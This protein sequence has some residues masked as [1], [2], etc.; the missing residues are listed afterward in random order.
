MG[1]PFAIIG[2]SM[3][4]TLFFIGFI[5][6]TAALVSA[7]LCV[8]FLVLFLSVKKLRRNKALLLSV[9][10]SLLAAGLFILSYNVYYLPVMKYV[11]K[12]MSFSGTLSDYP[13]YKYDRY[14]YEIKVNAVNGEKIAPFS[15]R[16]SFD[17]PVAADV[18]DTMVFKATAFE[19]SSNNEIGRLN[20]FSKKIFLGASSSGQ[21]SVIKNTKAFKGFSYY[22]KVYRHSLIESLQALM[23]DD[24][25]A[26]SS[27]VLTGDKSYIDSDILEK[28]NSVS[29]SHIICVSGLHLSIIGSFALMLFRK[30]K[31]S[32]KLRYFAAA[33]LI[34]FFMALCGFTSSILRAGI[35]FLIYIFAELIL[36]EPDSEN[37]LGFAA[38]IILLINPFTAVNIG[39]IF[40]FSATLSIIKIGAPLCEKY[41]EKFKITEK[42]KA[43]KLLFSLA[44]ILIIS[45][46]VNFIC[47][48]FSALIFGK[49]S[50][51]GIVANVL[52]LPF[53]SLLL[54]SSGIAALLGLLPIKIFGIVTYPAAF[55]N[56]SISAYTLK[57][58]ELLSKTK[59][60]SI[61]AGDKII[62]F[63]IALIIILIAFATL[64][65]KN[66]KA[67]SIVLICSF[68]LL[69]I[70]FFVSLEASGSKTEITAL[71]VG[72]GMCISIKCEDEFYLIDT[73]SDSNAYSKIKESLFS[74]MSDGID[75]LV[76]TSQS[77]SESGNFARIERNIKT[78]NILCSNFNALLEFSNTSNTAILN[79]SYKSENGAVIS[80]DEENQAVLFEYKSNRVLILNSEKTPLISLPE[81][82]RAFNYL[83]V[84][85]KANKYIVNPALNGI[86]EI[87]KTENKN[88]L[89]GYNIYSTSKGKDV[90]IIFSKYDN[91]IGYLN[92][93]RQ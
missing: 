71:S 61:C 80:F 43:V 34:V 11:D 58:V 68:L 16:V 63:S 77:R 39:F 13:D 65:I 83:I 6:Y 46:C 26:L 7:A 88:E 50:I 1:R 33:G 87:S 89:K 36:A 42:N 3:F 76:L 56:S 82:Y 86:I 79:E 32:R 66:K 4:A 41:K 29:I 44:E 67:L 18:S 54:I 75:C 74:S 23:P 40:S 78:D 21:V 20:Y 38:M 25:A 64:F 8:A 72:Y 81:R 17:E 57:I 51:I 48:P 69:P 22:L 19:N 45:I 27:A 62:L 70:S 60:S 31:V 59:F 53:A 9:F 49:V 91:Q 92:K 15:I 14:Y 5:G 52:I 10:S 28:I 37:S 2:L 84:K 73:G 30:L 12:E 90:R 35:M 55:I 93:W 24:N 85:G 47:L